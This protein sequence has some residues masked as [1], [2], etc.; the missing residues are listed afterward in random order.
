M[1]YFTNMFKVSTAD[2]GECEELI[3][4]IHAS[5]PQYSYRQVLDAC[6]EMC[7]RHPEPSL[8]SLRYFSTE[9]IPGN[10]TAYIR[11]FE[12]IMQDAIS[13]DSGGTSHR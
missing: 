4:M 3:R 9:L 11:Q 10:T 12:E 2:A 6:R 13:D 7:S 8:I 5:Y 1:M